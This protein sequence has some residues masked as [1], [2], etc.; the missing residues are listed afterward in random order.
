MLQLVVVLFCCASCIA[1]QT[2]IQKN[3]LTISP[4][5]QKIVDEVVENVLGEFADK[6]LKPENLAVTLVDLRDSS[7]PKSGNFRGNEKMYPASVVKLFYL[8]AVHQWLKE[9][10]I[11]DTPELRR[12]MR[13]MIV[14]SSNDATHFIVDLLTNATGGSEL[15]SR[16]LKKW[17][18]KREAV[19]RYFKSLGYENI[20]VVQK[21]Y[22]EDIYGRERQFW[23]NGRN[24]NML[25]TNATAR[26]LTE[27]VLGRAVDAKHSK[28]M[29]E[30]M[31][32]NPYDEEKDPDSQDVGFTGIALKKLPNAKLW[33]KAGWTSQSRHD[34]A[35]VETEDGLKFVLVTF[36]E[37]FAK[38]R[39]IIASVAE[40]VIESLRCLK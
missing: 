36:T 33:S 14:E 18:Y 20:K 15:P 4:E 17:I 12:A 34:A 5:I 19:D 28:Q 16:E 2:P 3:F 10:K 40:K 32:R 29:L 22:C 27:I 1:A 37:N 39:R 11:K 8:A 6:G 24:R 25:T 31:K 7:N 35:Y 38:E 21:T 13:D 30:L 26:L 9:G 23:N